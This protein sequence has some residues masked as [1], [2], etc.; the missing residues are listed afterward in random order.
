MVA[1]QVTAQWVMEARCSSVAKDMRRED[2][3]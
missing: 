2:V 3:V 1:K